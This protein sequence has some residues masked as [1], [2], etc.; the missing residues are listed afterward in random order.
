MDVSIIG[1][2]P[3]GLISSISAQRNNLN[4]CIYEEHNFCGKR[5]NCSGL[6]SKTGLETLTEFIDYKKLIKN[7]F[8]GAI[9][10]FAGEKI[11]IEKKED[12]AYLI[13]REKLDGALYSNAKGEGV[14][15][16]LN[17]RI[18]DFSGF[19][20][21]IGADGPNS[22]VAT[23]FKFPKIEKFVATAKTRI[24]YSCPDTKK[25]YLYYANKIFNGFFG[26]VIPQN[27]EECE[28][29]CG[30]ILPNNIKESFDRF[31]KKIGICPEK[32]LYS[33][34]P[35]KPRKKTAMQLGEKKIILVGDAAGQ[36]KSTTGGGVIFGGNCAK[37]AGIYNQNPLEYEKVWRKKFEF[38]L[39]L[40]SFAQS[41][42][43]KQSDQRLSQ[44]GNFIKKYD[45]DLY[46][47]E[48]GDM[49]RPSKLMNAGLI[50][51]FIKNIF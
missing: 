33:I 49:D 41:F 2:G 22:Q 5:E 23:Y 12:V 40:H 38:E 34:I 1:A 30:A 13:P 39:K 28:I 32:I 18:T 15:I 42:L 47:S 16:K 27:E 11:I 43:E 36:V 21:I 19:E 50:S 29:G 17:K 8:N 10:D 7:S 35:I 20:T 48:N 51:H 26:W 37:I 44:I 4:P 3:A 31:S 9:I 46:I 24:R 25:V 45:F 6:F 14:N